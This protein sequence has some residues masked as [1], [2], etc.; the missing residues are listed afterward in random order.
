MNRYETVDTFAS[1]SASADT[2]SYDARGNTLDDGIN[3]YTYDILHRQTVVTNTAAT[4]D[5]VRL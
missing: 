2:L 4:H 5:R 3:S 1:L